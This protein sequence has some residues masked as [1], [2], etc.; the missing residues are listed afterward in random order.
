MRRAQNDDDDEE[1]DDYEGDTVWSYC[2]L[3][4]RGF[5]LAS[6]THFFPFLSPSD[7]PHAG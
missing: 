6:H 4:G 5:S 7:T 1:E 3:C 2:N